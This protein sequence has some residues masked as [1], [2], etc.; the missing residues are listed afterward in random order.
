MKDIALV[1]IT[2]WEQ[3]FAAA[4]W[5]DAGRTIRDL[6]IRAKTSANELAVS[7]TCVRRVHIKDTKKAPRISAERF[8]WRAK[9]R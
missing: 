9:R 6:E 5:A 1:G 4:S 2:T 3:L 7:Q 8:S